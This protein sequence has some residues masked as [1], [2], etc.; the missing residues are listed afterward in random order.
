MHDI[1]YIAGIICGLAICVVIG[2]IFRLRRGKKSNQG[3]VEYDERQLLARGRA[4]KAGF[5]VTL[6]YCLLFA[7]L[8]V[9]EIAFF[10]SVTGMLIGVFLGIAVF[11]VTAI[12]ND[13]YLGLNE[14]KRSFL[15]LGIIVAAA[16]LII[17]VC[18]GLEGNLLKDGQLTF[19]CLNLMV[20]IL[21]TVIVA[22]LLIHDR[23]NKKEETE[24]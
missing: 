3:K 4:Y 20:G 17:G 21:F 24:E 13:A 12:R 19:D 7:A 15:I 18:N 9:T 8:S 6:I 1:A 11:A 14:N 5:F 22:A 2:L 10:Q 23:Q 16:N